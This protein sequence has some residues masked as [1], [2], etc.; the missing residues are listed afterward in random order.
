MADGEERTT[1]Y[2]KGAKK[3][4]KLLLDDGSYKQC[5]YPGR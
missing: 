4:A 1:K 3:Y 5:N 2:A